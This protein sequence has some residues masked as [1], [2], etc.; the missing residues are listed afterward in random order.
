MV[1]QPPPD[2]VPCPA[3]AGGWKT[4]PND[5]D[6]VAVSR[7][8][9]TRQDQATDPR[10]QYPNGRGPGAPEVYTIG[11]AHGDLA[12]FRSAFEKVYGGNLCV[13]QVKFSEAE[14]DAARDGSRQPDPEG[15]R[16]V[17]W[18][19]GS[20]EEDKVRVS[21]LVYDEALKTA[22]TPI[23]LDDLQLEVAVKPV[24]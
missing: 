3:P 17:L 16:G 15:S 12:A 19:G 6:K 7:F 10:V 8:L 4:A 23:G 13:H 9:D 1:S 21:A 18:R 5:F 11:V 24:R 20:S 2:Q 22:L 14:L